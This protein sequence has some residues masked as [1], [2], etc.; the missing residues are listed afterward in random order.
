MYN[1]L[2]LQLKTTKEYQKNLDLLVEYIEANQ[3][4]D[5]L[6]A[7]EVYL[8]GYDYDNFDASLAFYEKAME[9]ILPL[10]ST[11]LDLLF[12]PLHGEQW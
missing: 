12:Y 4:S 6:V 9:V 11:Q 2:L 3:E 5:L 7:P 10:I 1:I 8:T